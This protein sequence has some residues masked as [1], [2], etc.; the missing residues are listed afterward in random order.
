MVQGRWF[1]VLIRSQFVE[2]NDE[3]WRGILK[4]SFCFDENC[5]LKI[6]DYD[7]IF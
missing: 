5:L 1:F 2:L 4:I 6:Q 3:F 7:E